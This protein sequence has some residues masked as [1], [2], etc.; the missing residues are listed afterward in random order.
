[1]YLEEEKKQRA[2]LPL[3]AAIDE[4]MTTYI[5]RYLFCIFL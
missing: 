3:Y 5:Q 2:V 1:M 4:A